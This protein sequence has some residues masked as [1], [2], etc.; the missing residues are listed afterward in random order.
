MFRVGEQLAHALGEIRRKRE[1][2]AVIGRHL[3]LGG[4]RAGDDG[5]DLAQALEAQ[6]L[7]GEHEGVAW[8]E[9]LDEI[10][11]D[12]AEHA[13]GGAATVSALR[14]R[15]PHAEHRRLDDGADIEPVLL[16]DAGMGE[17]IV[18]FRR[19]LQ[20]GVALVIGERIAAGRDE[21]RRP[22]RSPRA[23]GPDRARRSS[24][25]DRAGRDRTGRRRRC[26]A[27]AGRARR[28][29]RA[30]TA[31]CPARPPPPPRA[32]PGTRSPRSGWPARAG[33]CSARRA[34]DW[35]GRC[36]GQAGSRPSARRH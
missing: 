20:L 17:A 36:A 3:G 33:P 35:R 2:A 24:P 13:A 14:P 29:R 4:V 9:L 34:G 21:L 27:R 25:R 7:A 26:R 11:L 6:H 30:A 23:S 19:L 16:G 28:A 12:L 31:A 1:L 10:F 22:C 18:A 32:P 15:E 8:R 5:I